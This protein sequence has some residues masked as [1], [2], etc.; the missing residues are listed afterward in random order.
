MIE[1]VSVE[2][3]NFRSFSHA[4]LTPF[5]IGQGMT[6]INGANGRGKSSLVHAVVWALYGVTPDGVPVKALR[7]QGSEG[8][9]RATIVF[10]HDNQTIEVTRALRGRNDTTIAAISLDGVEQTNIST[11]TATTW[12]ENRLGLDAEAFLTAFVVRQKE[13][14]SL[15]KA[16]PADRR[17]TIERLA[18][19]ERMSAA[20]DLARSDARQAARLLAALPETEDPDVAA[21]AVTVA[22]DTFRAAQTALTEARAALTSAAAADTAAQTAVTQA[23][24]A[25]QAV[26]TAE[27]AL[28]LATER[29]ENLNTEVAR[30]TKAAAGADQLPQAQSAAAAARQELD[31]ARQTLNSVTAIVAEAEAAATRAD[32]ADRAV[33]A[34]TQEVT[35]LSARVAT[36]TAE[37]DAFPA[38]LTEQ[39]HAA[40]TQASAL[41]DERGAAR[42]EWERLRKSIDS[43]TEATAAHAAVCPTCSHPLENTDTLIADLEASLDAIKDR[44]KRISD[45][46]AKAQATVDGLNAQVGARTR[47]SAQYEPAE[48]ALAAA[49]ARLTA[50][51]TAAQQASDAAETAAENAE[52]A[53]QAAATAKANLEALQATESQAQAAL[54][55][56]ESAG[57][58]AELLADATPR[59]TAAH[60]SVTNAQEA[61]DAATAAAAAIDLVALTD[62]ATAAATALTEA[63]DTLS[64]ANTDHA[65]AERDLE[66]AQ[67]DLTRAQAGAES[68][69]AALADVERTA[70]TASAL[71]EFRRDRLA[72]LAPELSEVAS[73]FVA[74]MMDGKYTAVELDEE[75][76]PVLTDA[77]GAQRPV[78]W[79]SGGEESAVALALRVAIG[80]V[81]AGQRGGLLI[82]DE[83]LTAQDAQRRQA[84]MGAIR[85]LPRQIITINHV[86]EATDMVDLVA[87]VIDD[88]DGASTVIEV[89]PDTLIGSDPTDAMID[90]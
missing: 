82:L 35:D 37:I 26:T 2:V 88:G 25:Q 33:T 10:R 27:H 63:Q 7:R 70:A 53:Q 13:L 16:R 24:A 42:G 59:L 30:L 64:A 29:Y 65:L 60:T 84:T 74:R 6:A 58:A 69:R 49:V 34:A 86:S 76:T 45:D 75:F 41:A 9:V 28:S 57:E 81:L 15:V 87:E 4:M 31:D 40:T 47:V 55:A 85:A 17:K 11:K 80:E 1:L 38:D 72:R 67:E 22:E 68:R 44:G 48:Q 83:V 56:A 89:A 62:T 46:L 39:L 3:L 78:A 32:N 5:G 51:E 8:E 43:L 54:R 21:K 36:I 14:D 19:I 23:R 73:D 50:A 61:L 79:L 77:S 52:T 90:A 66:T 12:I 20:L 71:E 18:G